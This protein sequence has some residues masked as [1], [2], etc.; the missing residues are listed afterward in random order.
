MFLVDLLYN[1]RKDPKKYEGTKWKQ[2][3]G[4]ALKYEVGLHGLKTTQEFE[5]DSRGDMKYDGYRLITYS[6]TEVEQITEW[7]PASFMAATEAVQAGKSAKL[8][9]DVTETIFDGSLQASYSNKILSFENVI[10]GEW[11]VKREDR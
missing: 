3:G 2:T 1:V 10:E 6:N 4:S 11:F 7:R 8:L 9:V 5:F